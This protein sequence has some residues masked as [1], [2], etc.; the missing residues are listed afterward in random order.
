MKPDL[1]KKIEQ[2]NR[3]YVKENKLDE[4]AI[5][6]IRVGTDLPAPNMVS[7]GNP[8]L[9]WALGGGI[10]ER[11][12]FEIYGTP[13]SS[14]T[15]SIAYIM[16]EVQKTG[17]YVIYYH[18]E[19]SLPPRQAWELAG[20][21]EDK[22]I[23]L[24]SRRCGE[25]GINMIRDIL[26]DERTKMPDPTIGMIAIDSLTSVAPQAEVASIEE[27][28]AE[29]ITMSRLAALTS[30]L[31]RD[32]CSC[33]WLSNGC[34][35][36]FISQERTNLS[37]HYAS[38]QATGGNAPPYYAKI[39]IR[40]TSGTKDGLIIG[41]DGKEVVGNTVNFSITKNNTGVP[42]YRTGSW[43]YRYGIGIDTTGPVINEA[44]SYG[45]IQLAGR[46]YTIRWLDEKNQPQSTVV[47]GRKNMEDTITNSDILSHLMRMHSIIRGIQQTGSLDFSEGTAISD[48]LPTDIIDLLKTK[49]EEPPTIERDE[50]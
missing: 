29:G 16:A 5:P 6:R 11:T 48:G 12:I 35:V 28:G 22:V 15:F 26:V 44:F 41:D 39:R 38:K 25:D 42:P 9:D 7:T 2:I 10:P 17:K 13:A 45:L 18:T 21:R 4:N 31:F 20:V 8:A 27:K 47:V 3:K 1:L 34:I 50:E 14:K 36:G 30:K 46:T 24:D 19:E 37:G 23:Y 33:G 43:V 40:L 49:T 32:I